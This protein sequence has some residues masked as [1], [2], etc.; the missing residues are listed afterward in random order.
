MVNQYLKNCSRCFLILLLSFLLAKSLS[1]SLP[2]AFSSVETWRGGGG[3]TAH[4][5]CMAGC[6]GGS[7]HVGCMLGW[8][9]RVHAT[10]CGGKTR[11]CASHSH[12]ALCQQIFFLTFPV[13][14]FTHSITSSSV[15]LF[16]LV[17][18]C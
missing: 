10:G 6:M 13:S 9:I 2:S 14:P 11:R 16:L 12:L 5:H 17:L 3:G 15:S 4:I 8:G 18:L 1:L 7:C